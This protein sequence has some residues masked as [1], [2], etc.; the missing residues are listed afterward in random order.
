MSPSQRLAIACWVTCVVATALSACGGDDSSDDVAPTAATPSAA[1]RLLANQYTNAIRDL[2][3]DAAALEAAPPDDSSVSGW[4]AIGAAEIAVGDLLVSRYDA[5]AR[6]VARA[7]VRDTRRI[8]DLAACEPDSQGDDVCLQGFVERFGR[9]AFRRHLDADEVAAYTDLGAEASMVI[10][11]YYSGIEHVIGAMLEAPSFLYIVETG[12]PDAAEPAARQL[13]GGE[14]AT[15]LSFA[16]WATT[17]SIELIDAAE[18]GEL[19]TPDGVRAA[20]RA[21]LEDPRAHEALYAF[22]DELLDLAVLPQTPKDRSVYA[23]YD[24]ALAAAMRRETLALLDRVVWDEP[25]DFLGVLDAPY[26]YVNGDLA[27]L[28]G[29]PPPANPGDFEWVDLPATG[30]RAGLFG[31]GAFLSIFAHP[32]STSPT[33]RG[34]FVLE[35][36]LCEPVPA[37]PPNVSTTLP[38][39]ADL[40][41]MRDKLAEHVV[42]PSC[43]SCHVKMDQ[44]GL[45]LENFDGIGAAREV[46]N[47]AAI[48]AKST[49]E[50][51]GTFAGARELGAAVRAHPYVGACLARNVLRHTA[52]RL[53]HDADAAELD[54]LVDGWRATGRRMQDLLVEL[55]ASRAF[56]TL[57]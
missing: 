16:L 1:R 44:V 2:L 12:E 36:F 33:R 56:R 29:L 48:D 18:R 27:S 24:E 37:P 49:A 17:P 21:M 19:D 31:E 14:M 22:Y 11:D 6:A 7:A 9:L 51:L 45:A 26:A 32:E 57:R 28:Y 46:D 4:N 53:E 8:D 15:R 42:N 54:T 40:P 39:G 23:A 50:G 13:T 38:E 52:G 5:S 55:V 25:G 47:G 10:G 3:G 34:R 43:A 41:T 20:A 30:V 35:T